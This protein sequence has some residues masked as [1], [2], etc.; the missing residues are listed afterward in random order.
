ML[1]FQ[2][3]LVK[4]SSFRLNTVWIPRD[5]LRRRSYRLAVIQYE[6]SEELQPQL[7]YMCL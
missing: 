2:I 5:E 3:A 4:G 6:S 7:P 1:L